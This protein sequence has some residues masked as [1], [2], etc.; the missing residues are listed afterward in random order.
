MLAAGCVGVA[1]PALS[2]RIWRFSQQRAPRPM[3]ERDGQIDIV[4]R[5]AAAHP[6]A[7]VGPIAEQRQDSARPSYI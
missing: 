7:G 5:R 6:L 3:R 1:L 4:P 2:S